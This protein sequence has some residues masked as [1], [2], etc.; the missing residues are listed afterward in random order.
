MKDVVDINLILQNGFF[1]SMHLL[2]R[3]EFLDLETFKLCSQLDHREVSLIRTKLK[4]PKETILRC[5]ELLLLAF[6]D[7]NDGKVHEAYRRSVLKRFAECRELLKPYFRFE[8]F[9]DRSMYS[10]NDLGEQ[11]A[12]LREKCCIGNGQLACLMNRR[13]SINQQS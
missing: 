13:I 10:I 2:G 5:F 4:L 1:N 12:K 6:L 7:P 8:N 11:D 9:A 3:G